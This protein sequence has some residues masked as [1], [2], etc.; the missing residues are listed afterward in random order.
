MEKRGGSY[1]TLIAP[2]GQ[3]ASQARHSVQSAGLTTWA[4]PPLISI[5]LAGQTSAHVPTPLHFLR[6]TTGGILHPLSY[7]M[8]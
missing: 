4:L 7:H 3:E 2:S 5:T 1:G 8:D 6:S